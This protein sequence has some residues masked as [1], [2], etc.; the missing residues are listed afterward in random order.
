[1]MKK[2]MLGMFVILSQQIS[3]AQYKLSGKVNDGETKSPLENATITI[4]QNAVAQ[5]NSNGEFSTRFTKK[6]TY[7]IHISSI[8][9]KTW[10]QEIVVSEK[11]TNLVFLLDRQNLFLKPI[12]VNAIRAGDRMPFSKTNLSKKDLEKTNLGQDLPFLLNQTPS[13]VVNSDAGNGIGYTGIRIRGTDATRINVT[14][15]GIPYND[16]ES[17]G[18]YFVDLPDFSSSVNSVQIQR[19]VGT[20]SNGAGAFGATLN[21]STNEFNEKPSAEINT[22]GGSFNTWRQTIKAGSGLMGNHFTVDARLSFINSDGFIDRGS[23]ALSSFY[24]STA[25]INKKTS[26]RFN[27]FTGKEKTYQAWNGI[28][29][30]K[31]KRNDDM[32]MEHY[33]NNAYYLYPTKADSLNLFDNNN[34]RTY[35]VFTYKNQ[36]DNYQQDH[37]QLFLNHELNKQLNLNAAFFL[38]RGRGYYEEYKYQE[39]LSDYGLSNTGSADLIRQLW[40]NNWFYGTT[41]SAQYKKEK[42]QLTIGGAYTR[43]KGLHYGKVIWSDAAIPKDYKWYDLNAFKNDFN[44]YAKYQR[45]LTTRL[46]GF[47]DVQYRHVLHEINGFRNNPN[48]KLDNQFS[49]VNPKL[50]I[51]YADTKGWLGFA[52]FSVGNK[53]PNREDFEAGINQQPKHETLY[54]LE[55]NIERRNAM[56]SWSATGYYMYYNNQLV[57]TGRINDV[58]SY[59]RTNIPKSYRAGVELQAT[60]KPATWLNAAANLTLSSNRILNFTEYV[61]DYDNGGQKVNF[62]TSSFLSFSPETIA[63]ATVNF[64]PVKNGE[65]S[66]LNKY[67]SRQYLDNTGNEAR[68]IDPFF[69]SDLRLSYAVRMKRLKEINFVFQL[70]NIW[71]KLYEANGYTY[72]YIYNAQT[73]TENFYYPMAGRNFLAGINIKL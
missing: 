28:P 45:R 40:L 25:Y 52:S 27:T 70:N 34:N 36:T 22:G 72:S 71:N 32:L 42:D 56:Y 8:G 39:T 63:G 16:A 6:G 24:F 37:Y 3:V 73:I 23:S 64:I 58:G 47:A 49:F 67:V 48:L 10:Q 43:Y 68:S 2:L 55:L 1:M 4:N 46:E 5:T 50:G 12:E 31:L 30:A 26:V 62:F 44:L 66:L 21:L 7:R 61:D 29:E 69:V 9:Y 65:I 20:S 35:N 18:T 57:L 54:D 38:T 41:F 59:T 33:L 60:V 13:V 53:E 19:G 15:N 14:L 51:S 17:Q 11:E